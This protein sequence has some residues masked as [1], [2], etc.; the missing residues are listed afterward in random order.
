MRRQPLTRERILEQA[1]ALIEANGEHALTMRRLGSALGVEAMSLY[2]HIA[3]RDE[4]VEAIA[5]RTFESLDDLDLGHDWRE[6]THRF[7]HALRR[8]AFDHPQTFRLVGLQPLDAP[9]AVAERFLTVAI[10]GGFTPPDALALYRA[11][12]SYA[13]GYALAEAN[14]FTVDFARPNARSFMA[15]LPP[16]DFPTL[17]GHA[18]EFAALDPDDGFARGLDA[19]LTGFGS[20]RVPRDR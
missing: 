13:R 15:A 16:D 8:I 17:S 7:G 14:G 11:V 10:E 9:L 3:N 2:H 1:V 6:A 20:A 12:A 18:E 5:A 4:L 19:L